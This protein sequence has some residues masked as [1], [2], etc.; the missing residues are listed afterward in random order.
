MKETR[1]QTKSSARKGDFQ[2]TGAVCVGFLYSENL[3]YDMLSVGNK[4]RHV[5]TEHEIVLEILIQIV[6]RL[7]VE[8]TQKVL[9][10]FQVFLR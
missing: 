7:V 10:A 8:K 4:K 1:F 6:E 3:K 9:V 5:I 2:T